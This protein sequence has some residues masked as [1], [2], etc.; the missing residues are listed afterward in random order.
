LVVEPCAETLAMVMEQAKT[1]GLSIMTAPDPHVALAMMDMAS[2]DVLMTD[3]FLPEPNGLMLIRETLKRNT[4][5]AV[6]ATT[7]AGNEQALLEA[8]RAGAGDCLYKPAQGRRTRRGA[9]SGAPAESLRPSM[10]SR[11]SSSWSIAWSSEPIPAT[12]NPA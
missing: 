6:I 11:A 5:T 10:M 1:R 2:P 3:L 12:L 7:R 8:V 9:G 4:R